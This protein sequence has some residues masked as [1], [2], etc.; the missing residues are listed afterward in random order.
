MKDTNSSA[1]FVFRSAIVGL[2]IALLIIAF[3]PQ[4]FSDTTPQHPVVE[5]KQA[6][7]PA[8]PLGA[9]QGDNIGPVSY[10]KA[11]ES[12]APAVVNIYSTKVITERASPYANDPF[13]RFLFGDQGS[14]RKRLESSLG[15]GVIASAQG[16]VLTNNHVIEGADEIQVALRDNRSAEAKVVGT[17]PESDLAVLKIDLPELPS[18]TFAKSADISI[19]D[20]A[21][22]IGNPFGVGQTVTMGII[23]ATGR[24]RVGINTF[25]NFIQTDAAINPG[26]SGGAL[27][28]AYGQLIGINTAIFSKSGGSQGIGFAIPVDSAVTVMQQ[29]VESGQVQR[30]WLGIEVQDLNPALAESFG[31]DSLKGAVIAGLLREGPGATAG[32]RPGDVIVQIGEEAILDSRA[33]MNAIAAVAPGKTVSVS[34]LRNGSKQTVSAQVGKRPS[35]PPPE[36]MPR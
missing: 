34:V 25:E 24:D 33:V 26:N 36:N 19:G 4:W 14:P 8:T 13:F 3:K 29:L 20:V 7:T 28:N 32:L 30:G 31:L 27:V 18:I 12:A 6:G 9:N 35:L 2:A 11:V 15:S 5:V 22:A 21:L 23:S 17:D 1:R 10:S 16:Y